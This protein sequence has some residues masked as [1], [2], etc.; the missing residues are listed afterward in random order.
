MPTNQQVTYKQV[1]GF[2]HL[3]TFMHEGNIGEGYLTTVDLEKKIREGINI[4]DPAVS[5]KVQQSSFNKPFVL[6][7]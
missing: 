5:K 7:V 3:D 1:A 4:R 6:N 2:L